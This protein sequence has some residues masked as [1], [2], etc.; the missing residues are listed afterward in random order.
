M[1]V[2]AIISDRLKELGADG[3][4]NESCG[5]GL[6][7]LAPCGE[8][9]GYCEPAKRRIATKKDA[10]SHLYGDWEVGDTIY[11]PMKPKETK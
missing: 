4:C 3:L 1:N 2:L 6:S 11:V 9:F 5:C 8:H 10:D 7:D